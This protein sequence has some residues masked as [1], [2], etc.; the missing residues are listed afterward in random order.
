MRSDLREGI[1]LVSTCGAR[2][3]T[4]DK[5]LGQ[6]ACS[7]V[8][9]TDNLRLCAKHRKGQNLLGFRIHGSAPT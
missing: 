3:R 7:A 1:Y 9:R 2:F 6:L 8:A 4:G 5:A